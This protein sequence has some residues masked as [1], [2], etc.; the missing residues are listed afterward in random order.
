RV[1]RTLGA[2]AGDAVAYP[3]TSVRRIDRDDHP[4]GAVTERRRSFQPVAHLFQ[5]RAPAQTAGGVQ[6]FSNLIGTGAR[7]LEQTHAGLLDL[8][9]LG[10]DADD[11][12]GRAHEHAPGGRGWLRHLLQLEPAVLVL[13][14]L[15]HVGLSD[16]NWFTRQFIDSLDG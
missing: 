3:K 6:D 16:A 1:K 11:R 14:D 13:C 10:A 15:L 12:M 2:G 4:R 9:F 5:G 7:L 8:H